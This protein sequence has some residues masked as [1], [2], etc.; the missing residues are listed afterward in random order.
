[1]STRPVMDID[2]EEI[3][4]TSLAVQ[5]PPGA[6]TTGIILMVVAVLIG[7]TMLAVWIAGLVR[8]GSCGGTGAVIFWVTLVLGLLPT[9]ITQFVAFVL[10]CIALAQLKPGRSALG[11][12]C[13]KKK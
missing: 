5:S 7:L 8:M 13:P 10:A 2:D 4:R 11:I 1:M 12:T 9:G 3:E 6:V